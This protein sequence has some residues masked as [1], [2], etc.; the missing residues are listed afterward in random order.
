M[1]PDDLQSASVPFTAAVAIVSM[2]WSSV[3]TLKALR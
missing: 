1:H 3:A 2:F